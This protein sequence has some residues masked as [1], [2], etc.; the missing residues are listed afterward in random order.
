[1]RPP[2]SGAEFH[3]DFNI[4]YPVAMALLEEDPKLNEMRFKLV[5]KQ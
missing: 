5:P 4:A 1:M 3:F 2:P